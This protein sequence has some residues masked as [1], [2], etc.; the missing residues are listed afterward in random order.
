MK[1][2]ILALDQGT[3]SSTALLLD[4][5]NFSVVAQ[6]SHE[7]P[8][9]YPRPGW[10]EH[11]LDAIWA[12]LFKS[13]GKVLQLA[14]I[15][16]FQIDAIG[17][18]NQRETTCAFDREGKAMTRAIVWQDRR[19]TEYCERLNKN[20]SLVKKINLC[21]GLPTDPYFSATKMAWLL[22][23]KPGKYLLG[24][25]DSFL[26][27]RLTGGKVFATDASNASRTLLYDLKKADWNDELLKLFGIH[28]NRLPEVR[29]S[30]TFFGHTGKIPHLPE[31]IPITCILGDQQAALFGQGCVEKGEMKCT[32][33]T[34]AFAM[35]N[36]GSEIIRSH[37]GLLTT[38][39]YRYNNQNI[40]AL[41][42]SCF[43]AGAAVQW[44]RD[45]LKIIKSSAEIEA[46]AR[47]VKNPKLLENLFFLPFFSGLG[48]PY[49]RPEAKASICGMTRDT[50]AT[51]LAYAC[52]EGIAFSV[53]D[54]LDSMQK[55]AHHR[56]KELKVDGGA[57]KN[58]LLLSLQ[59]S[60]SQTKVLRPKV[61]ET[62]AFGAGLGAAVGLGQVELKRVA[63]LWKKENTF[64]PD[65]KLSLFYK[66]KKELWDS[67]I[68]KLYLTKK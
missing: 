59:A 63:K 44:L 40:F 37:H 50:A 53:N 19:T 42:G 7:H 26:L 20:P 22:K 48:S 55:D 4:S 64:V 34:G 23:N 9:F 61:I 41:E 25:I 35:M 58:N 15:K 38:V 16:G 68:Q 36:T 5:K 49:W 1:T 62:T 65:K 52:L 2:Y 28:E 13:I 66:N 24:T 6:A 46:L 18:T 60:L 12:S 10:V 43:I 54:L 31:G 57:V 21:T 33:G 29:D 51:E 32:Y 14:K 47:Q 27:F 67:L 3:T 56:L 8:Q 11:D 39:A 30:F 17:I 45:N